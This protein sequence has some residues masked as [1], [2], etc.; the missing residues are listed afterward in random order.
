MGILH[1]LGLQEPFKGLFAGMSEAAAIARLEAA[2]PKY[3]RVLE[4]LLVGEDADAIA[5]SKLRRIESDELTKSSADSQDDRRRRIAEA[6]RTPERIRVFS[7]SYKRNPDIVAE[8]LARANGHCEA[9]R[10]P[11]P[12][13]RASDGSPYLEVHHH[14]SLSEGGEDTLENVTAICPN[15]HREIHHGQVDALEV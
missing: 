11:A 5:L 6:P 10:K 7:Y 1:H 13:R 4:H 2:G 8:A 3:R 12:F 15:C 9:C 14:I